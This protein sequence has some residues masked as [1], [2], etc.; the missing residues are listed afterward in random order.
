MIFEG[1]GLGFNGETILSAATATDGV[2]RRCGYFI[3][4]RP[5]LADEEMGLLR[6]I[7]ERTGVGRFKGEHTAKPAYAC[8]SIWPMCRATA[9]WSLAIA[10]RCIWHWAAA[11]DAFP[12][13]P[14]PVHGKY[15]DTG[16]RKRLFRHF[17]K[18]F[19]ISAAMTRAQLRRSVVDEVFSAVMNQLSAAAPAAK[20]M[21]SQGNQP[22]QAT[23]TR[24]SFAEL[25]VTRSV[26]ILRQA[27]QMR[28]LVLPLTPIP[29]LMCWSRATL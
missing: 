27:R 18:S 29:A 13:S 4:C 19:S 20:A 14:V 11:C 12:F 24:K 25:F 10:C 26:L 5:D 3:H 1:L 21:A 16:C 2:A 8:L 28:G 7:E 9:V 15:T 17:W 23:V 6:R 22:S